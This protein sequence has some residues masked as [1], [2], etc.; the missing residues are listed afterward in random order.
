MSGQSQRYCPLANEISK[1]ETP[2]MTED[3][4]P[5]FNPARKSHSDGLF[6]DAEVGLAHRNHGF[7]LEGLRHDVTPA[8]MHY[9][10]IHFDV[11]FVAQPA[12]WTLSIG[13]L[14]ERPLSFRL[15]EIEALPQVTQRVTLEC[16]GNG[17]S[18]HKPRWPSQPW[19]HEAVGTAE[20]T[21]T[22]LKAVLQK[23]GL[24]AGAQDVVFYGADRGFDAG[25][26][27]DYGR[28]LTPQLA[29]G[30]DVLLV[31]AMNGQPLLPQHGAPLRLIVPGWYGMAS[32]KWLNRIEVIDHPFQGFQQVG[33]YIFKQKESEEGVPVTTIRVKSL[34]VP[35]GM[36][37]WYTRR[38]LVER[39]PV[40]LF[41]RAWSGAGVPIAKVEVGVDGHY[42]QA[43]LDPPSGKYA[44]RGWRFTWQAAPGEYELSCRAT[45]ANGGIQP[46]EQRFDRAGF[47]NNAVHRVLVTVR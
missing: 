44:W 47:G 11:P 42:T 13:G 36:P 15:A 31:T 21:G 39:G 22:P 5:I 43:K 46:L 32:V 37:D 16:A 29:L 6:E 3:V 17:R 41:G 40:T 25:V 45:D 38:R 28:S 18:L 10:L 2:L 33:T 27:H 20:W 12:N 26:E 35:P 4:H 1:P 14:V 7:L 30:D 23:A 9:L 8:G 34:M 24:E 19:H